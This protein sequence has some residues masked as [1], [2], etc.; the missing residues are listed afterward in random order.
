M[1]GICC[2]LSITWH[3]LSTVAT[4]LLSAIYASGYCLE[5]NVYRL[6]TTIHLSVH[7]HCSAVYYPQSLYCRHLSAAYCL[8][9]PS[10]VH[11]QLSII[12]CLLTPECCLVYTIHCPLL[13]FVAVYLHCCH[14]FE[15]SLSPWTMVNYYSYQ[16]ESIYS[17]IQYTVLY[18]FLLLPTVGRSYK[19]SRSS[20]KM[21]LK[22]FS[23]HIYIYTYKYI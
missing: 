22:D 23:I 16:K 4:C 10:T 2:L 15:N 8:L 5:L 20:N 3:L 9:S 18:S 13:S 17:Y 11:C 14:L 12:Y 21:W 19:V 6:L 7:C 1:L